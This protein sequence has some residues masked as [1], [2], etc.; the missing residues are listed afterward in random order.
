[1]AIHIIVETI[2]KLCK[3]L[4]KLGEAVFRN[5]G[6]GLQALILNLSPPFLFSGYKTF[7]LFADILSNNHQTFSLL[8][9][10]GRKKMYFFIFGFGRDI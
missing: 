5:E 9:R 6:R 7:E 4:T 3:Y 8:L 1:M 2:C 10:E